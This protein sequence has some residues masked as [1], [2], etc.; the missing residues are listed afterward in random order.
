MALE[1]HTTEHS[2]PKKA[3]GAFYG[4]KTDAKHDSNRRRR[5]D[6]RVAAAELDAEPSDDDDSIALDAPLL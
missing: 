5:E 1:A 3:R 6:D 2:G 4:H